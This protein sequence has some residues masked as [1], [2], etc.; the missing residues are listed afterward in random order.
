[1]GRTLSTF[2]VVPGDGGPPT[3]AMGSRATDL[4]LGR[5]NLTI[6]DL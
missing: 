3:A 1:M 6:Q 5:L 2:H 4:L